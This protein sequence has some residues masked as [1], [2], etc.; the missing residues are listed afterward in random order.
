MIVGMRT[1]IVWFLTLAVERQSDFRTTDVIHMYTLITTKRAPYRIIIEETMRHADDTTHPFPTRAKHCQVR[2]EAVNPSPRMPQ[3]LG[4]REAE[5]WYVRRLYHGDC[6]AE[7]LACSVVVFSFRSTPRASNMHRRSTRRFASMIMR[8]VATATWWP[9]WYLPCPR[10]SLHE[11]GHHLESS[12]PASGPD[13]RNN[14]N[15]Y[16]GCDAPVRQQFTR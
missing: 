16:D 9:P 3:G 8:I 15:K 7:S 6:N 11:D 1:C 13:K 10:H 14:N 12:I 4:R 5:R 2:V